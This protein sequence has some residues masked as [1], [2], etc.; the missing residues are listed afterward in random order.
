MLLITHDGY[1]K[2]LSKKAFLATTEPTK[3]KDGDVITDI[4]ETSTTDTLIQFTDKGNYIFYLF[5]KFPKLNIRIWDF[6]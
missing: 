5:T 3:L 2:R 1:L 6:M 4:Y